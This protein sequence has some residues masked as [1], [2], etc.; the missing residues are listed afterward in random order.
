M[1]R[2]ATLAVLFLA[3]W[4]ILRLASTSTVNPALTGVSSTPVFSFSYAPIRTDVLIY[5]NTDGRGRCF[6]PALRASQSNRISNKLSF[7]DPKFFRIRISQIED[8]TETTS[9]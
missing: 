1:D 8:Q 3:R 7:P 9:R 2:D 6:P 5:Q 4:G